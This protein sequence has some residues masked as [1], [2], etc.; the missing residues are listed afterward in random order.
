MGIMKKRGAWSFGG[1]VPNK[2]EKHIENSIPYYLEGHE[3]IKK[4]FQIFFLFDSSQCYDIGCSTG[5]LLINLSKF[6][7][8]KN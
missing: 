2:F 4:N 7:N 6:S 3:I 5:N 1:K 8:K